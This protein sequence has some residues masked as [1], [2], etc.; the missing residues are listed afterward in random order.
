[1]CIRDRSK[2]KWVKDNE[3]DIYDKIDKI[4]LPGDYIAMKLTGQALTT[5]A[6][7]T[8]G[9]FW[10][11]NEKKISNEVLSFFGFDESILANTT[12]TFSIQGRVTKQAATRTGL[13]SGTPITY[14][15]GD[16]PNNAMSLN[17]LSPGEV[18]ATSGTS[19][20]VYGLSLIHI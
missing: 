7:L 19:G 2:L 13:K 18:A 15:A 5:V 3:P 4:L 1:M 6:G 8:E 12:P 10:D 20:V 17:V 16:Q 9:I 14:R 11:F